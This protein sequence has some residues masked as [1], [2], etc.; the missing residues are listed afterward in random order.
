MGIEGTKPE[1]R[2]RL[3]RP[4]GGF[5]I[6]LEPAVAALVDQFC[7]RSDSH[8]AYWK[9]IVARLGFTAHVEGVA[10]ERFGSGHRL[11]AT[12][13]DSQRDLPRVRLVYVVLGQFVRIKVAHFDEADRSV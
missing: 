9:D 2:V 6:H 13:G 11:W 12:V 1:Q 8:Q 3:A 4:P 7:Q 10:D 5:K